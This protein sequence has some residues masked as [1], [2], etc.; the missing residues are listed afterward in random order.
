MLKAM[1]DRQACLLANHGQI[2]FGP[3]LEKA[4]WRAGEVET[5]CH[6]YWAAVQA[7]KPVMLSD[8]QMTTVLARFK[9][10]GKQPDELKK[11][12]AQSVIQ[13]EQVRKVYL[14]ESFGEGITGEEER[15]LEL[16][17]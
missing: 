17:L 7:G 2:A 15:G 8:R 4:L 13:N 10:Y 1:K 14:G 16:D 3:N 11:G 9:T 12:D 5:L 6:Q